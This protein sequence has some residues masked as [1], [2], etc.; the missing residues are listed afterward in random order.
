MDKSNIKIRNLEKTASGQCQQ[1]HI[2]IPLGDESGL[3]VGWS[4][5]HADFMARVTQVL[6]TVQ[7]ND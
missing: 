5:C 7:A 2:C 4:E 3:V 1:V 6:Q